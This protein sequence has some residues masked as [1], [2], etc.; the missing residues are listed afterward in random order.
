M[1]FLFRALPFLADAGASALRGPVGAAT[2]LLTLPTALERLNATL[3][4]VRD[5]VGAMRQGVERL[6]DGVGG[7]RDD[8]AAI[9]G[10]VG[11][12]NAEVAPM[13]VGVDTL[14]GDVLAVAD[15]FDELHAD[16]SRLP[17]VRRRGNG[18]NQPSS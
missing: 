8:F 3:A 1:L 18:S 13:R 15:R 7:L 12:L 9:R 6:V 5:E 14:H 11:T 17:F 2:A 16:L 4:D 10:E